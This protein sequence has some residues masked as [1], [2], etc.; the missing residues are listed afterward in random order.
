MRRSFV[1]C[2]CGDREKVIVVVDEVIYIPAERLVRG[3][4]VILGRKG[5]ASIVLVEPLG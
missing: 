2:G 5:P 4:A 3:G 1:Y